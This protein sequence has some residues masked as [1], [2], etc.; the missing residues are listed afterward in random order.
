[1]KRFLI[2]LFIIITQLN[3]YSQRVGLVLSGGGARGIAHIGVIQALE[4]NNVPIDYIAG[5]SMGAIVGAMYSMGYSTDEMIALLLSDEFKLWQSGKVDQNMINYFKMND[6][7]PDFFKVRTSF[8][9]SV[10]IKRKILPQS[11]IDP[12]PMNFAFMKLF[13]SST[14]RAKGSFDNLFV[15]LRTVA[16]DVYNKRPI[17]FNGGDLGDAVRASMTFPFVFKPIEING[18]L[19]YDGGIYNNFP[20]DVMKKDFNPDFIIGSVVSENPAKPD[21]DDLMNQ[22]ENMVMQKTNYDIDSIDGVCL[23]FKLDKITLLDF[24]KAEEIYKIG[25]EKG[26]EYMDT[27]KARV[28]REMPKEQLALN[29]SVYRGSEPEIMFSDVKI[30]GG[31]KYQ[32]RYIKDQF[33][34]NDG[35]KLSIDDVE[36]VYFSLTS[37]SKITEI[38]PKVELDDQGNYDLNLKV[39]LNQDLETYIGGFVT[40]MNS[41][42]IAIGA[43]YRMLNLYASDMGVD[44]QFGKSYN[45]VSPHIRIDLPLIVP[46]YLKAKY[47]YIGQKYYESDKLFS[48]EDRPC[49]IDQRENYGLF[50]IG[51]GLSPRAKMVYGVGYAHLRDAYYQSK[52]SNFGEDRADASHYYF[53]SVK[54]GGEINKITSKDY[55]I[56]GY[57]HKIQAK[58]ILGN[59]RYVPSITL[60]QEDDKIDLTTDF[61][62]WLQIR[63]NTEYYYSLSEKF[64][65]GWSAEV[66]ASDKPFFANYTSTILQ[67]PAFQPTPHSK[68]VFNENYRAMNYCALGI[69]P[70]FKFNDLFHIRAEF[71]GYQPLRKIVSGEQNKAAYKPFKFAPET[72]SELSAVFNLPFTSIAIFVNNY[73][74]PKGEWNFGINIGYLIN[75]QRFVE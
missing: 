25:Y 51:M 15:P 32:T 8:S 7:T 56:K 71:Y 58:Y 49:F 9:D 59:E 44:A 60:D 23:K 10:S 66:F 28:L 75:T 26:M 53:F 6:P 20:V 29:R 45:T 62:R 74:A 65:L 34:R 36:K 21:E 41:N 33:I 67:A 14:I 70:I 55:P 72:I 64:I 4:D 48:K 24:Y 39:K 43:S 16:S 19:A 68:V 17:I 38:M 42:R 61:S 46:F 57:R 47:A 35:K 11:L 54:G 69:K 3:A 50:E 2:S 40:S 73:S 30:S 13:A 27:I 37:D 18:V 1:M 22:I 63:Y 12:L 5:T 31:D 52:Y